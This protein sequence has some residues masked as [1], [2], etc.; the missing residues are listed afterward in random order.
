[1]FWHLIDL[2]WSS[3]DR[4]Y[5]ASAT[6]FS[7]NFLLYS[8]KIDD[9]NWMQDFAT[10]LRTPNNCRAHAPHPLV[11]RL[12]AKLRWH[13]SSTRLLYANCKWCK[14][15]NNF[16]FTLRI[17]KLFWI[18]LSGMGSIPDFESQFKFELKSSCIPESIPSQT[19]S[20]LCFNNPEPS[21]ISIAFLI[22]VS[23][24]AGMCKFYE[25]WIIYRLRLSPNFTLPNHIDIE[26]YLR[27]IIRPAPHH[28]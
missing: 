12:D 15:H 8:K 21:D 5:P 10:F 23:D 1:M 3:I 26:Y 11:R 4:C 6:H 17:P 25:F 18:G 7:D 22:F 9:W 28:L 27:E 19:K 2:R 20:P 16:E 13:R 24:D 14:K